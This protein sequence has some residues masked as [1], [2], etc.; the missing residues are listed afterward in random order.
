MPAH[1]I[2]VRPLIHGYLDLLEPRPHNQVRIAGWIFRE[3]IALESVDIALDGHPWVSSLRLHERPDVRAAYQK[4][5]GDRPH[6]AWSG[7]DVVAPIP[8]NIHARSPMV[9]SL[10]P[11]RKDGTQID[12]F[13]TYSVD[14]AA[15][16][17][18]PPIHLQDR[19]GGSANFLAVARQLTSFLLS[20]IGKWQSVFEADAILDWGCGC[21][22]VVAQLM[23]LLPPEKLHG[24][25][26]DAEAIAWDQA[27]LSGPSFLRIGPYPPTPYPERSFDIIYGISVMTHLG[28]AAQRAWLKELQRIMR[29]GG[30]LALSVIGRDL[31]ARNMPPNLGLEF[32]GKGFAAF[33]PNYSEMLSEFSHSGY[34][35]EAYHSLEYIYAV[36]PEYFEILEYVETGHQDIVLL[37]AK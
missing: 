13:V 1:P 6:L 11:Y 10:T 35:Q 7:F 14:E 9:V 32:S 25:D 18:Q 36:W 5:M 17:P 33:V 4:I 22:R 19:I 29:P 8:A 34:Y 21:G 2:P 15:P 26:I 28:E 23:R 12:S 30:V 31:R 24:C 20:C 3:D 27:N 16:Q 37:R